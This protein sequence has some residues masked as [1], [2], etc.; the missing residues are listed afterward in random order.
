[1]REGLVQA[2]TFLPPLEPIRIIVKITRH[3][4]WPWLPSISIRNPSP[5]GRSETSFSHAR[6]V[7]GRAGCH[8][9]ITQRRH[10]DWV[11][12]SQPV[13]LSVPISLFAFSLAL[14]LSLA[15]TRA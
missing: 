10:F 11:L 12:A 3:W 7:A 4:L 2:D 5:S 6:I 13:C 15:G 8:G 9:N 1:M 14:S